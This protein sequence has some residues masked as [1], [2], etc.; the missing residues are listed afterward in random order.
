MAA[1]QMIKEVLT[2]FSWQAEFSVLFVWSGSSTLM[3][4]MLLMAECCSPGWLLTG[5]DCSPQPY[6]HNHLVPVSD[7]QAKGRLPL[8]CGSFT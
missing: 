4:L 7:F 6:G 2:A 8:S 3:L 1:R 5:Q